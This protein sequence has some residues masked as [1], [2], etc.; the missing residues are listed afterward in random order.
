MENRVVSFL[1]Q[2]P[3]YEPEAD[4]APDA[5][6]AAP[7]AV[8]G[9]EET[10]K[11]MSTFTFLFRFVSLQEEASAPK[12]AED[13]NEEKEPEDKEEK[14]KEALPNNSAPYEGTQQDFKEPCLPKP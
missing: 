9:A 3:V 11:T 1:H 4:A 2:V 14:E 10:T 8:G 12:T 5:A 13:G 6:E 7:A